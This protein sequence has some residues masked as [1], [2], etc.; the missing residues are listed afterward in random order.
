MPWFFNYDNKLHGYHREEGFCKGSAPDKAGWRIY[1][2]PPEI[3]ARFIH[4]SDFDLKNNVFLP[5]RYYKRR[6][7]EAERRINRKYSDL[8]EAQIR[9]RY[10]IEDEIRIL[11]RKKVRPEE[12][13][14]WYYWCEDAK[15]NAKLAMKAEEQYLNGKQIE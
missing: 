7:L 11:R 13:Q 12:Y 15:K 6:A 3:D 5:E 14:D 9:E 8:V 2:I 1:D 10:T 4:M